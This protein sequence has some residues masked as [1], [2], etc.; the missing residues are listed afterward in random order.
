MRHP[1]AA[2]TLL[3]AVL[4]LGLVPEPSLAQGQSEKVPLPPGGFKPPPAAPVKPYKPVAIT[5]PAP[6]TD[7]SFTAFRKQLGDIAE[8]K[9]RAALAK[10][11][12][13]QGFFW[14]QDK[15]LADKRK[16]G[17]DN[18]AKAIDLDARDGSGWD[19]LTGYAAEP[20]AAPWADHQGV[21]CAPANPDIDPKAF[22]ALTEATQTDPAEWGYPLKDGL[23]VRS[24]AKP[25]APVTEKLGLTLVRMLPETAPPSDPNQM[26]MHVA[27]PT[28]KTGFVGGEAFSGLGGDEMCYL[29]DAS[30]WKITGYFGGAGE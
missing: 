27:T 5:P 14:L 10:L 8:H 4:M 18:L 9:D 12:V 1:F 13:T 16:S 23:E 22:E 19:V 30:G 11:V 21:M 15:D 25:D 6:F 7:A 17:I 2:L 29:K 24:A 28:G 20:T 3:A 26:F